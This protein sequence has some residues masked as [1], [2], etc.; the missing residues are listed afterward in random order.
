M[1]S[2]LRNGSLMARLTPLA[3]E[4]I[5]E[6]SPEEPRRRYRG[7]M[8]RPLRPDEEYVKSSLIAA[9]ELTTVCEQ[10][11]YSVEFLSGLRARRTASGEPITR[12]DYVVYHMENH[13]I[14]TGSLLDRA[15]HVVNVVFRLGVPEREC[16]FAVIADND[17]VRK[18]PVASALNSLERTI[19]PYRGQ[20]NVV[21]HRRRHS[22]AGLERI[23]PYY[24]I[25]KSES[26]ESDDNVT[27]RFFDAYK[28]QTDEFIAAKKC[29]LSKFNVE[30]FS[31]ASNVL[32]QMEP[33]FKITHERLRGTA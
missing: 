12:L 33:I 3:A 28:R 22:E 29:E 20:R 32:S 19:K 11:T 23:E 8:L 14:R 4:I 15:L 16:R 30:A 25:Q 27:E 6:T 31:S 18:S 21:I 24:L 10:M 2:D 26:T 17:H 1:L 7:E 9:G 13:L 5:R